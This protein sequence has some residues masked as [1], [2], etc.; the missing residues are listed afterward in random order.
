MKNELKIIPYKKLHVNFISQLFFSTPFLSHQ[1][2]FCV[3]DLPFY[4]YCTCSHGLRTN[5]NLWRK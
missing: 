2:L 5:N 4:K 1:K 3:S